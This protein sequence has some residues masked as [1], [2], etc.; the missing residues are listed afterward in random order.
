MLAGRDGPAVAEVGRCAGHSGPDPALEVT[1][2]PLGD[3]LGAPVG[4]EAGEVEPKR[5]GAP[6]QV[7]IVLMPVIGVDRVD[8][9]PEG[10]LSLAGGRLR[11]RVQRRR[12]R[13][14]GGD[15]K[16]A[17]AEPD[18]L[19][20]KPRPGSGAVRTGEIEVGDRLRALADDMVVLADRRNVGAGQLRQAR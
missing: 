1:P 18:R 20:A 12:A 6:P 7:R 3:R 5:L 14:L 10:V 8:H 13:A 11:R 2:Y 15:R 9:L 4:F 19:G 17:K 16:V